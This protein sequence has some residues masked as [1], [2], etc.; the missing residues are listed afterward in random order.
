M[1][2]SLEPEAG[3]GPRPEAADEA[4]SDTLPP[5]YTGRLYLMF[6]SSLGQEEIA[7][8]WEILEDLAAGTIVEKRLVSR[9]AEIQF[10]ID[11]G[12]KVFSL[13]LLRKRMPGAKPEALEAD[14]LKVEWPRTG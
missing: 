8:V 13:E 14:R 11:L 10:T 3:D 6:P 1:P 4:A 5:T 7:I 12:T 9:A 2:A